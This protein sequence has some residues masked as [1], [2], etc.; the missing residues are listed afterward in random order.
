MRP[1][2]R[3]RLTA[4]FFLI[5]YSCLMNGFLKHLVPTNS[6]NCCI[7]RRECIWIDE[8]LFQCRTMLCQPFTEHSHNAFIYTAMKGTSVTKTV[9]RCT[10][11]VLCIRM[12]KAPP[13]SPANGSDKAHVSL[14][15]LQ[16]AIYAAC[17]FP[18]ECHHAHAAA[19]HDQNTAGMPHVST[20]RVTISA[21]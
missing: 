4:D 8:G 19:K 11:A 9:S 21:A 17:P 15:F 12:A 16:H 18:A 6:Y 3:F 10:T 20:A 13:L 7:I 2:A 1:F 14:H 5:W